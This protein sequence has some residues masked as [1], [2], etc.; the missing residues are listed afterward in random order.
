MTFA[1]LQHEK[2]NHRANVLIYSDY[3]FA[4]LF[5]KAMPSLWNLSKV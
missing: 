1:E 3:G 5:L 4:G 2:I